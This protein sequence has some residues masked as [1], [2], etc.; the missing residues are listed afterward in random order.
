MNADRLNRAITMAT[1][2]AI[3]S[4]FLI[5]NAMFYEILMLQL[6]QWADATSMQVWSSSP[7]Y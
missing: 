1:I 4:C 7:L 2:A 3:A 6:S 5:A